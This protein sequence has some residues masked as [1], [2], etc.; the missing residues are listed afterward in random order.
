MNIWHF[1]SKDRL[2]QKIEFA[3]IRDGELLLHPSDSSKDI[4]KGQLCNYIYCLPSILSAMNFSDGNETEVIK[5][6]LKSNARIFKFEGNPKNLNYADLKES[7]DAIDMIIDSTDFSEIR[8]RQILLINSL[9]VQK[10]E[11]SLDVDFLPDLKVEWDKVQSKAFHPKD[12]FMID[13]TS[14]EVKSAARLNS[15]A[16]GLM[17][18]P[19]EILKSDEHVVTEGLKRLGALGGERSEKQNRKRS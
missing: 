11:H 4:S 3:S 18:F 1:R 15:K 17:E 8:F 5:I 6:S 12:F 13:F 14:E 16:M 2:Y 10:W 19:P 7:Y 9:A